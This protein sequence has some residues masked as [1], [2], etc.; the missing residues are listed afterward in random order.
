M[1]NSL[2]DPE[3]RESIKNA[4]EMWYAPITKESSERDFANYGL[5]ILAFLE[6]VKFE[7]ESHK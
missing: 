7:K 2:D 5:F 6:G 4:Y 3:I 1:Q